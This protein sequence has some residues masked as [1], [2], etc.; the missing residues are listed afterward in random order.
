MIDKKNYLATGFIPEKARKSSQE[1]IKALLEPG[2]SNEYIK[3]L[4]IKEAAVNPLM[5]IDFNATLKKRK[6]G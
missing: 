4:I 2:T 1:K 6:A 5:S 3:S